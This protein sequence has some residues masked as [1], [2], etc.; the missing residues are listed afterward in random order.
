ML[1]LRTV[2]VPSDSKRYDLDPKMLLNG[3][4]RHAA[5]GWHAILPL[6]KVNHRLWLQELPVSGSSIA[7][8]LQLD[9]DFD[10]RSQA[11][12]RFWLALE[13]RPSGPSLLSLSLQRRQRLILSMR[14]LDGW[15]AGNSYR[16]I[17]IGL[18][19]RQRL[20]E[21]GWKTHD[22]RNRTIRLVQT[23]VSMMRGGYRALLRRAKR[24]R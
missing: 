19:G 9:S 18:F 5:D 22:L 1:K 21:R 11:A 10:T 8:E 6:G 4:L 23:G 14:A 15:L 13:Q 7:V 2:L 3:E 24:S 12:L 17:A 16:D 20:P